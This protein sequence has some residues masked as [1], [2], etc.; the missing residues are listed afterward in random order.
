LVVTV[1]RADVWPING[2]HLYMCRHRVVR[3]GHYTTSVFTNLQRKQFS[4]VAVSS[5]PLQYFYNTL[6]LS[7]L[8]FHVRHTHTYIYI[9][10]Y[11]IY[12]EWM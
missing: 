1:L 9:Y 10:I 12:D 5:P 11:S 8:L 7:M 2:T 6:Q 3:I 4:I